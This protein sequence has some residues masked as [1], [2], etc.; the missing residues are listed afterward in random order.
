MRILLLTAGT[1]GDVEPFAALGRR[2]VARGHRV[3]L[4]APDNSGA[5]LTG[6][7]VTS[8]GVDFRRLIETHGVSPARALRRFAGVVRPLMRDVLVNAARAAMEDRP[9]IIVSHP[10]ILSAPLAARALDVPHVL[11]ET[12]PALTAT[13]AYPAAGTFPR[14]MGPLNRL[15]YSLARG[16]EAMF[17]RELDEVAKMVGEGSR[18]APA[19][20][21]TLL[22]ISPAILPRPVDWPTS[23]HLTGC[24]SDARGRE[25]VDP[26]IETFMGGGPFVYA[27]FGSMAT[28]GAA[29][30]GEAVV[31]AAREQGLR[32]LA[33]TGLGGLEVPRGLHGPDVMVVESV[34]HAPVLRRAD[35]AIHHGGI[36]TVQAAL[37]A[38]T[39][40]VVVPFIADQPFWGAR[41]HERDLAPA[42]IRAGRLSAR[43]LSAALRSLDR[44]RPGVTDVAAAMAGENG[45]DNAL[46]VIEGR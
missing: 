30:R 10:K 33:A 4:V 25:R 11:V 28:A 16:A 35:A 5:E 43:K 9:D 15:S 36:G 13:S 39:P 17:R 31:R 2:A 32:V 24:W 23:V 22:P 20:G 21:A 26:R 12:V 44:Y 45:M 42:P 34:P 46:D 27:G 37:G 14:T 1:R 41:L 8:L 6:V 7:D 19:P 40:A 38:G 3:R 18:T 29:E